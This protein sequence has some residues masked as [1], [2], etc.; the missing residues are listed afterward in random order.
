MNSLAPIFSQDLSIHNV[1][2]VKNRSD[3]FMDRVLVIFNNGQTMS[4][5]CGEC[6]YGGDKGLFE[7]MVSDNMIYGEEYENHG[8]V[9]HLTAAQV[10]IYIE[11]LGNL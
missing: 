9:G 1:K 7:I 4:I 2:S 10:M 5:I 11:K 8:V 3:S 6:S